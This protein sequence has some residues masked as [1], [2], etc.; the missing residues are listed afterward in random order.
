MLEEV[1][2]RGGSIFIPVFV[3]FILS[4]ESVL[5]EQ[6]RPRGTPLVNAITDRFMLQKS[7]NTD[8]KPA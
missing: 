3:Q 8:E 1:A 5:A 4:P 6:W 7:E 2:E